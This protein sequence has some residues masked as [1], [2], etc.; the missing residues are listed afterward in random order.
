MK[1][2]YFGGSSTID[3]DMP[4]VKAMQDKGVDV[5][6]YVGIPHKFQRSNVVE[7][8]K[9]FKGWGIYKASDIQD[10]KMFSDC[11]DL[12][13]MYF[14]AGYRGHAN[15]WPFT[16]I[17]W[18]YAVL[19]MRC[20]R[21]DVFHSVWPFRKYTKLL[22][23]V[24]LKGKRVLTVH[25][26]AQHSNQPGYEQEE[27]N[28]R[29]MFSWVDRLILLNEK[30]VD[31]FVE[32]YEIDKSRITISHLGSYSCIDKVKPSKEQFDTPFILFFGQI[33][34]YKG[35]EYLL[36]AMHNI[37]QIHPNVKLIV[38]GSGKFDFDVT[39]YLNLEYIE[40]R[41]YYVGI[42]ELSSLLKNCLFSVCPYKDSTQSGVVQTAFSAGTPLVVSNVGIMAET[43][44]QING[45]IIVPPM[46]KEALSEACVYLISHTDEIRQ[47]RDNIRA[48]WSRLMS[49]DSISDDYMECYQKLL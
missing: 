13:R 3:C 23:L 17:L 29:S 34:P 18:L 24:G 48:N 1:V 36:K 49:W 38:A 40:W 31:S 27:K 19:H 30:Q 28:R 21:A 32:D 26:P 46:N 41:H 11:V 12:E 25:D 37:H 9:P 43:V 20:Q 8:K 39:P 7:F 6:Y 45:G 15:W 16:W 2:I 4:V 14:I 42:G 33:L 47:F 44:R 22:R 10:M 5:R 35:L